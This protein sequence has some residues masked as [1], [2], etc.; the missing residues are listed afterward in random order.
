LAWDRSSGPH[1]GR[2]YLTL[3]DAPFAGSAD[4]DIFLVWSDDLGG[5]W[6]PRVRVNDDTGTN[7]QFL[8]HISL[9]QSSGYVAVTWYDCRNSV[10]NTTAQYFGA[11]STNGGASFSANFQIS[12]GVSSEASS[13]PALKDADYGDYTGNA[14]AEGMLIPAWADN[15]NSTGDNPDGPTDFEVY[16]APVYVLPSLHLTYAKTNVTVSW[17]TNSGGFILQEN[18]S[19]NPLNW[20]NIA[21][22][23]QLSGGQAH[24]SFG[25]TNAQRFFRLRHP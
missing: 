1:R 10:S 3:T 24:I 4:T 23:A 25:P 21:V 8:P 7:S 5:T 9:D 20:T 19:L 17:A 15:S 2:V 12:A 16:T 6:S 11:I 18:P 13:V 14:F 22:A